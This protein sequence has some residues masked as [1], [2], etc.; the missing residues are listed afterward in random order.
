VEDHLSDELDPLQAGPVVVVEVNCE[1]CVRT[2]AKPPHPCE[3]ARA[4]WLVVD[5][6]PRCALVDRVRNGQHP[7]AP[8]VVGDAQVT[9]TLLPEEPM[10]PPGEV[11]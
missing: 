1:A 6:C 11:F 9:H 7:R 4:L 8:G 10:C 2:L 3:L 5:R